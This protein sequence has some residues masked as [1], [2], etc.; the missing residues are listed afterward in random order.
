MTDQA[1]Q[2]EQQPTGDNHLSLSGATYLVADT[3]LVS[4][5]AYG[6]YQFHR[7]GD[8]KNRNGKI[9]SAMTGAGWAIGGVAAFFFGNPPNDMRA[10]IEARNL[11]RY[12]K[13]HD[14]QI[15]QSVRDNHPLIKPLGMMGRVKEFLYTYPSEILNGVFAIFS[16]G[17][18]RGGITAYANKHSHASDRNALWSGLAVLAGALGGLFIKEDADA[19]K[20]AENGNPVDKA[21][22]WVK[23]KPLR[24]SSSMYLLNNVFL[25]RQAWQELRDK[26]KSFPITATAFAC[27]TTANVMLGLSSRDA[28]KHAGINPEQLQQIKNLAVEIVAA[29]PKHKR[30]HVF[31][32]VMQYLETERGLNMSSD[33][34]NQQLSSDVES[35]TQRRIDAAAERGWRARQEAQKNVGQDREQAASL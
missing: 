4:T 1:K 5:H 34:L 23:E 12:L 20:K 30:A 2:N 35:A 21:I 32:E 27:Y 22:A 28:A 7:H 26:N 6:A 19:G 11:D 24:F 9:A 15:P 18:I 14:I 8:M 29:Q 3:A 10:R 17:L 13:A 31:N 16:V 33:Q 25:G